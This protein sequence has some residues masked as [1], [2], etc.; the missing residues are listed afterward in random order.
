MLF[1]VVAIWL[2]FRECGVLS[3]AVRGGGLPETGPDPLQARARVVGK[4]MPRNGYPKPRNEPEREFSARGATAESYNLRG[5]AEPTA[6]NGAEYQVAPGPTG[7][8]ESPPKEGYNAFGSAIV[9]MEGAGSARR[10]AIHRTYPDEGDESSGSV[11]VGAST[12]PWR[13]FEQQP[14]E[15]ADLSYDSVTQAPPEGYVERCTC[16]LNC[17]DIDNPEPSAPATQ[18]TLDIWSELEF[19]KPPTGR[20]IPAIKY[21]TVVGVFEMGQS[22]RRVSWR[23]QAGSYLELAPVSPRNLRKRTSVP[24]KSIGG[25]D[26]CALEVP[27]QIVPSSA[28]HHK[29]MKGDLKPVREWIGAYIDG[30]R[31]ADIPITIRFKPCDL[32]AIQQRAR[33]LQDSMPAPHV[34]FSVQSSGAAGTSDELS[35]ADAT[36]PGDAVVAAHVTIT[37]WRGMDALFLYSDCCCQYYSGGSV[38]VSVV[39]QWLSGTAGARDAAT[40]LSGEMKAYF[41][42]DDF[43]DAARSFLSTGLPVCRRSLTCPDVP[44]EQVFSGSFS[45]FLSGEEVEVWLEGQSQAESD[46]QVQCQAAAKSALLQTQ[47]GKLDIPDNIH[48]SVVDDTQ[49]TESIEVVRREHG[50]VRQLRQDEKLVGAIFGTQRTWCELELFEYHDRFTGAMCWCVALRSVSS[51]IAAHTE[52]S[53]WI[54][55]SLFPASPWPAHAQELWQDLRRVVDDDRAVDPK[56]WLGIPKQLADLPQCFASRDEA[57]VYLGQLQTMGQLAANNK[58]LITHE[59]ARPMTCNVADAFTPILKINAREMVRYVVDPLAFSWEGYKAVEQHVDTTRWVRDLHR[60]LQDHTGALQ[61]EPCCILIWVHGF[62]NTLESAD[63]RLRVVHNSYAGEEG[64]CVLLGFFWNSKP[65][66]KTAF[67]AGKQAADISASGLAE[68]LTQLKARYPRSR[69]N[70]AGHSLGCRLILRAVQLAP[71]DL[72]NSVVL[73]NAA[74]PNDSMSPGGAYYNVWKNIGGLLTIVHDHNDDVLSTYYPA[75]NIPWQLPIVAG[76]ALG[77]T[78]PYPANALAG[79]ATVLDMTPHI[80]IQPTLEGD[81]HSWVYNKH[82]SQHFFTHEFPNLI[83]GERAYCER[84]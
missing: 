70:L 52:L 24:T 8:L 4:N 7:M 64:C 29:F 61:Y 66:F 9:R 25:S 5:Q 79:M 76:A 54:Q 78:G 50:Y 84:A 41:E 47:Y 3:P 42:G 73:F 74:V 20:D 69:I 36:A 56:S 82:A 71:Q 23:V 33:H 81:R 27:F 35:S 12:A 16:T 13:G 32:E 62:D 15:D 48:V 1:G 19:R 45:K 30:V 49:L 37:A 34:H 67:G 57:L 72:V 83:E 39:L 14:V 43:A 53:H 31:C 77:K 80:A 17:I 21:N 59:W 58:L 68:L 18:C 65:P 2:P 6:E 63:H 55:H 28:A 40:A 60:L 26:P 46:R 11:S 38:E 10:P 22:R 75:G 44:P 51:D